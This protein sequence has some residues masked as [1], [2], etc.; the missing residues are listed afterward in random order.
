MI[1][2]ALLGT[3]APQSVDLAAVGDVMLGRYVARRLDR[4]GPQSVFKS[5]Q[6]ELAKA[7][8]AFGN[9]ES[10]LTDRP[11]KGV[12][13]FQLRGKTPYATGLQWAG[14]DVLSLANNHA[15][16][17]GPE[18]L[19][20]TSAAL[21][22]VGIEPLQE[23]KTA[24]IQKKGLKIAFLGFCD[25]PHRPLA[26]RLSQ[27]TEARAKADVVIV[28]WHWGDEG[29][30]KVNQRQKQIA[31]Q[32]ASV[33]ADLILGSHPHVLQPVQWIAGGSGR[34]CLVAYSLGNFVFDAKKGQTSKTALLHVTIHKGGVESFRMTPYQITRYEPVLSS[35]WNR[36]RRIIR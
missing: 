17:C 32:M 22:Q 36:N 1:L 9:L 6:P 5:A 12:K 16:D 14:F 25:F 31:R 23:G 11:F 21:S 29:T 13:H 3:L 27:M 35:K 33:G 2:W 24:W 4:D 18:G 20:D 28:A 10:A 30:S 7:D 34:R 19:S 26:P 15:G 8:L